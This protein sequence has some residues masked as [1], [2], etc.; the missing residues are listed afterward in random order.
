MY[1]IGRIVK[2]QGIKGE[3]KIEIITSFPEHFLDF[4]ELFIDINSKLQAYSIESVRLSDRFV[5]IKFDGVNDRDEAEFLRNKD[6]LIPVDKLMQLEKDEFYI[7]DLIGM[8]V[9]NE[10]GTLLGEIVDVVSH[11][12][13][14]IYVMK[15]LKN[16]EILIPAVK[17]IIQDIDKS[18]RKIVIHAIDGLLD[19]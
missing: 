17:D 18:A 15:N 12:S 5:Y 7:H 9:F 1:T 16:E 3:V 11:K 6:L 13:N 10:K 8:N 4:D 19:A 14:D 2:P